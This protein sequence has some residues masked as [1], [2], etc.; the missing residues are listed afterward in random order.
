MF[1]HVLGE[2]FK[3]RENQKVRPMILSI[4]KGLNQRQ[5]EIGYEW[6]IEINAQG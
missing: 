2:V 1:L 4:Y 6:R 3:I 5:T